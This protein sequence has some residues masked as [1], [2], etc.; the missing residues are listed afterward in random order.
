MFYDTCMWIFY[1]TDFHT[2]S[3]NWNIIT[4]MLRKTLSR[5]FWNKTSLMGNLNMESKSWPIQI[6]HSAKSTGLTNNYL[7]ILYI[8][9]S[10]VKCF[11]ISII[12]FVFSMYLCRLP[13]AHTCFNQLVL[14]SYKSRK[15][16]KQKLVIA[17]QNAE[18][19]G[20][21]WPLTSELGTSVTADLTVLKYQH[22]RSL[23]QK[24]WNLS[25]LSWCESF[26]GN[27]S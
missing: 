1:S 6:T 25:Y 22:L 18:G 10:K 20:I 3:L 17:I 2:Y 21:E 14:P 26:I 23:S 24:K 9:K 4:A 7:Y 15:M 11:D 5:F 16:L 27:N 19:F 8:L 13:S 12:L